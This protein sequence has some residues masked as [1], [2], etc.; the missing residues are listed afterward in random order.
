MEPGKIEIT[1]QAEVDTLFQVPR[2][3]SKPAALRESITKADIGAR[4]DLIETGG[5]CLAQGKLDLALARVDFPAGKMRFTNGDHRIDARVDGAG[6]LS[7]GDRLLAEGDR[8]AGVEG[9]PTEPRQR[10][11]GHRQFRSCRVP[12][13]AARSRRRPRAPRQ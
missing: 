12:A 2:G 11:V 8:V 7:Q 6:L 5:G 3:R 4:S 1:I 10:A 13:P 9:R